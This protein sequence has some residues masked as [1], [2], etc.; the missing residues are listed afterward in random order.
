[1]GSLLNLLKSGVPT[2]SN[3]PD[4]GCGEVY[5][6]RMREIVRQGD[7]GESRGPAGWGGLPLAGKPQ[8]LLREEAG[9]VPASYVV[10]FTSSG[11]WCGPCMHIDPEVKDLAQLLY[12]RGSPII[13]ATVYCDRARSGWQ[14][15]QSCKS[16]G[17]QGLPRLVFVS[18]VATAQSDTWRVRMCNPLAKT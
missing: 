17:V 7:L 3:L 8:L 18:S 14:S 16:L 12:E 4:R 1:M 9:G 15:Q 5:A 10:L 13:V 11:G 2:C 6:D